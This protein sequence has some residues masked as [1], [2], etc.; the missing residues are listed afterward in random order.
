HWRGGTVTHHE[1]TPGRR[2]YT[3]LDRYDELREGVT[4]LRGDGMTAN[5]IAE[6]LNPPGYVGPRGE[7]YTGHRG[8]QVVGRFGL[9][10]I[11]ACVAGDSDRDAEGEWWLAALAAELGAKPIVVHRWRWSGWVRAR[12]LPGDNGRWIVWAD[13]REITRLRRLR[14]FEIT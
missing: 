1:I 3:A 10:W 9:S 4:A 12:Q 6:G 2:R 8:R 11:A 7:G 14:A 5:Q 13:A